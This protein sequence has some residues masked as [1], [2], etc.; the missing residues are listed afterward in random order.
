MSSFTT[1]LKLEF[2]D[3]KTWKVTEEFI[4]RIGD[5][6]SPNLIHVPAGF[7]TDF[8]SVPRFF[9]RILPPTGE[10]GKAAVVHDYLYATHQ[11]SG[12]TKKDVDK[13]FLEAMGVLGVDEWKRQ[14]MY[15]AVKLFGFAAW[16]S[17]EKP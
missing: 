6:N 16:R 13:I 12:I 9:W 3:G 8:A 14:S 11:E 2:G 10:Y 15:W 7:E 4:Y 17:H 5:E 1:P